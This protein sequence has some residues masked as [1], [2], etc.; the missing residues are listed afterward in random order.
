V[1]GVAAALSAGAGKARAQEP[2]PPPA[3]GP[4]YTP[5]QP[6]PDGFRLESRFRIHWIAGGFALFGASWAGAVAMAFGFNPDNEHRYNNY[7][8]IP[9]GGSIAWAVKT[10]STNVG[11]SLFVPVSVVPAVLQVTGAALA[12]AGFAM[13][14]KELRPDQAGWRLLPMN[15]GERG[16]GLGAAGTF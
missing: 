10:K 1:L 6:V 9:F 15:V 2:P 12:I 16:Y 11:G 5:G 4:V 14:T 8:F 3:S 13:P 7:G